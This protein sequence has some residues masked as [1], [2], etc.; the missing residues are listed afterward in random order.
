MTDSMRPAGRQTAAKVDRFSYSETALPWQR[1]AD[2][3]FTDH[4]VQFSQ[5]LSSSG[6]NQEG[7]TG[8]ET[9]RETDR[10]W[11]RED[12]TRADRQECVSVFTIV[13]TSVSSNVCP[14]ANVNQVRSKRTTGTIGYATFCHPFKSA[15]I[16]NWTDH[17]AGGESSSVC[18]L[19]KGCKCVNDRLFHVSRDETKTLQE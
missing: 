8:R 6:N 13:R 10:Q 19:V 9:G 12:G 2:R 15:I 14:T 4:R 7:Q 16:N 11:D 1:T 5:S 18:V 17:R 3:S